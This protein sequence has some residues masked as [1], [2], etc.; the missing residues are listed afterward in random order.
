MSSSQKV[1]KDD[2]GSS[3]AVPPYD[4]NTNNSIAKQESSA[5]LLLLFYSLLMFTLPF[6]AFFGTQYL[7]RTYSDFSEF[8]ITSLSVASAVIT[9]YLIIFSY[10]Y[11]AYT[12]KEIVIPGELTSKKKK[13]N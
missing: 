12:E 3:A 7:L 1:K 13:L 11:K 2:P 9:V 10:A 8:A 4:E 6:G 5:L